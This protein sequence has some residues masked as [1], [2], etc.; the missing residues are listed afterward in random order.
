MILIATNVL[1]QL[2]SPTITD[3]NAYDVIHHISGMHHQVAAKH[4]LTHLSTIQ[5]LENVFVHQILPTFKI[6]SVLLATS[7]ASGILQ[8][9][10]V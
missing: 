4:V 10:D 6:Q 5:T 2:T 3:N 1:A 9:L 7:Q 8:H